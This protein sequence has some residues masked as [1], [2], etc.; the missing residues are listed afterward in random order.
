MA[1]IRIWSIVFYL[2]VSGLLKASSHVPVLTAVWSD[3]GVPAAVLDDGFLSV[4]GLGALLDRVSP[5]RAGQP[6]TR[7]D[8][9]YLVD[10][11]PGLRRVLN[12]DV[13]QGR[14]ERH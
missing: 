2:S 14:V 1:S 10:V 12:V 9:S 5:L 6:L 7:L 11:D 8:P 4:P 13:H 3:V